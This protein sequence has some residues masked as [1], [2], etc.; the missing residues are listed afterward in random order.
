MVWTQTFFW[1]SKL[2]FTLCINFG[3]NLF[4]IN[5]WLLVFGCLQGSAVKSSFWTLFFSQL[6]MALWLSNLELGFSNLG[7]K[8]R[9]L[10]SQFLTQTDTI[11][12]SRFPNF[13]LEKQHFLVYFNGP[14]IAHRWLD[15]FFAFPLSI[16][17]MLI[18]ELVLKNWKAGKTKL[19]ERG[20]CE[21]ATVL[22]LAAHG[23]A[24]WQKI[25]QYNLIPT[26]FEFEMFNRVTTIFEILEILK[27]PS[28]FSVL[29]NKIDSK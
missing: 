28:R 22:A 24:K 10:N 27:G 21:R 9:V 18:N 16:L 17:E 2:R 13:K 7:F 25:R 15:C 14:R 4:L 29:I 12:F 19:C 5:C 8:T 1:V 11:S 20:S 3:F 26:N 6:I 23:W